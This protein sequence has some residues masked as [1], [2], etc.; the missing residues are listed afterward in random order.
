MK[1]LGFFVFA[2]LIA[3]LA[4]A[5]AAPGCGS[6]KPKHK[7]A[8]DADAGVDAG[9]E[10]EIAGDTSGE[11]TGSEP[12]DT[13]SEPADTGSEPADTGSETPAKGPAV[14]PPAPANDFSGRSTKDYLISIRKAQVL[15]A[16]GTGECWD[17]C[18]GK[19]QTAIG[20]AVGQL[21]ALPPTSQGAFDTPAKVLQMAVGVAGG[22]DALPDVFVHIRCGHGQG[23]VTNKGAAKN[24]IAP[25]WTYENKT[26]S[27][28][29]RDVCAISLW[30]ADDD[31][32]EEIGRVEVPLVQRAN[33][34]G[35]KAVIFGAEDGFGLVYSLEIGVKAKD[36]AGGG[37]TGGGTT[38]GGKAE[39]NV[40]KAQYT[41]EIVKAQIQKTKKDGKEWDAAPKQGSGGILGALAGA[42]AAVDGKDVDAYVEAWFNGYLSQ[43]PFITTSVKKENYYP[44]WN[45][46][47]GLT[48]KDTDFINFMVWDKDAVNP[49]LIGECKTKPLGVQGMGEIKLEKCGQ[50]D[51]LIV[52]ITKN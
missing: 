1:R 7:T 14:F 8:A 31:G 32:D 49:D 30:D 27:L 52:K 23:H 22:T 47:G 50:V 41:V 51:Y 24:K 21:G 20:T 16:K 18:D 38:G 3:L 4:L 10:E 34:G 6:K 2:S 12:A 46:S 26:M 5:L 19:A 17:E 25:T 43:A 37:T 40:P 36:A 35:G 15:P 29:E 45:E 44:V 13:G 42:A 33:S 9:D 48:L 39:V 11:D 28:D